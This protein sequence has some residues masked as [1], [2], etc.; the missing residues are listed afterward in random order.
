MRKE[1]MGMSAARRVILFLVIVGSIALS[2][3]GESG[4]KYE[5]ANVHGKVTFQGKPLAFG[6]ILFMP[7]ETPKEGPIQ[8]AS[9]AINPDGTYELTSQSTPGAV[10]G[11]HK[12]VVI[13]VEGGKIAPPPAAAKDGVQA[14]VA[15]TKGSKELQLKSAVPK[16]Y[17]DP[18]STPLTRKV[19][20]GDNSIDIELTN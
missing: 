13:A 3:C 2:G 8:P 12:V 17:S 10:L 7:V 1:W 6:T 20:A 11:E 5:H 18:T 4:I 16:K 14:P 9:G 19:V 15:A